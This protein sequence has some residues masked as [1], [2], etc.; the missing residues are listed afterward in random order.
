M[1]SKIILGIVG[2][3]G[4]F[5]YT[6]YMKLVDSIAY[7]V[8][9]FKI[10]M[11]GQLI[12]LNFIMD[13]NNNT[14]KNLQIDSITGDIYNGKDFIAT[15]NVNEN[16]NIKNNSV[17]SLPINAIVNSKDI[18]DLISKSLISLNSSFTIN[19]KTN[20]KFEILGLIGIPVIIK[21]TTTYSAS[22]FL[23]QIKSVISKF[24][25]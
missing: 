4:Y 7:K 20:I 13:I 17:T 16:Y 5:E 25:K 9:D 24:Q 19:S 22:N 12:E 8:R 6:R 23:T 11:N 18:L 10:K 1:N 15:F 3:V 14:D 21:D 2:A